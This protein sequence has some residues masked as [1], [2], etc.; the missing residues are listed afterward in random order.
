MKQRGFT[1]IELLA[2]LVII[3][4]LAG[5]AIPGFSIWL[6]N[7]RVKGA[8]R[9]VYS[10]LQ[11]AKSGAIKDRKDWAVVFDVS[12][13]RY[14]V[15]SDFGG[16]NSVEKTVN[17]SDYGS[18]VGYGH[19]DATKKA[20]TSGGPIG[21]DVSFTADT[22]VFNSRG[23]INSNAGG[24]VYLQNDKSTSFAVGVWKSGLVVL[25]KWQ[26]GTWVQ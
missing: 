16:G 25:R 10:N 21:D 2:V 14:S 5:I 20:T 24:Y 13:N 11:L 12:N 7:Y 18:G 4:V 23:M 6:P 22:V 17:F 26:D 19:G 3:G 8:A 9:D 15:V 1:L